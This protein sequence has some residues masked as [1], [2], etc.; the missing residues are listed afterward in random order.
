MRPS[1]SGWAA[2]ITASRSVR[3]LARVHQLCVL[4][5]QLPMGVFQGMVRRGRQALAEHAAGLYPW[6]PSRMYLGGVMDVPGRC[7]TCLCIR[8]GTAAGLFLFRC[9]SSGRSFHAPYSRPCT[10]LDAPR[11]NSCAC[12]CAATKVVRHSRYLYR[13]L[14]NRVGQPP[15]EEAPWQRDG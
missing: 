13:I 12:T 7:C 5:W 11:E 4:T 2:A 8:A 3:A 1:T 15:K 10:P 9:S 6:E 14:S